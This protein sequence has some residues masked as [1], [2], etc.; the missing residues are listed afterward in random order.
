M[1]PVIRFDAKTRELLA[2][3]FG[4]HKPFFVVRRD[5]IIGGPGPDS[6]LGSALGFRVYLSNG[7]NT[8]T[9]PRV[10]GL[11]LGDKLYLGEDEEVYEWHP[12]FDREYMAVG[13][14]QPEA[15]AF[16]LHPIIYH[17]DRRNS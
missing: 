11:D 2:K 9:V 6:D 13:D 12:H 17:K 3:I 10:K 14:S 8:V 15:L 5:T 7:T 16:E 1:T 4:I